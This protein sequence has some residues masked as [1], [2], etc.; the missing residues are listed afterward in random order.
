MSTRRL[1]GIILEGTV[2]S[3]NRQADGR[4]A[5]RLYGDGFEV[6]LDGLRAHGYIADHSLLD[7][8]ALTPAGLAAARRAIS[9]ALTE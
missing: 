7:H 6:A 4:E 2:R 1:L 5:R 8:I 3:P 9:S